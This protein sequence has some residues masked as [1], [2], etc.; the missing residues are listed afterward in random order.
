VTPAIAPD[1]AAPDGE[2]RPRWLQALVDS[3]FQP[4]SP[5]WTDAET[6]AYAEGPMLATLTIRGLSWL[7]MMVFI[8]ISGFG[9]RVVA[10][11]CIGAALMKLGFF[12]PSWSRWH[13]RLALW[14]IGVGLPLEILTALMGLATDFEISLLKVA[15]EMTHYVGSLA[16]A[17]GYL[18]AVTGIVTSGRLTALS[19][20]IA[21]VGRT[22]LSNYLGQ[23]LIAT[24]IMYW[25]GLGLFGSV[26]RPAQIGLVCAIY[27]LQV[28]VSVLWLRSFRIGPME[29]LWRS[30]TYR[31]PQ[32]FLRRP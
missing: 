16:L 3:E 9:L 11:F 1:E 23:T 13:R 15:A 4:K 18:G 25:W 12:S 5:S 10:T 6:L 31:E 32:P 19:Q 7:M 22:A 2:E 17:F 24:T 21:A 26:S 28:V 27:A 30:L 8:L 20:G 29:W 14:G